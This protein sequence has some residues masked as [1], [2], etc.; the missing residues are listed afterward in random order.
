VR[1]AV[2]SAP[3]SAPL[4]LFTLGVGGGASTELC[5]GIAREGNGACSMALEVDDLVLKSARL[6]NAMQVPTVEELIVDW[7]ASGQGMS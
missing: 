7:E 1:W 6:V 2:S 4:R 5:E 3:A